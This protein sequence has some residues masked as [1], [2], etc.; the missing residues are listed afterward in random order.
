MLHLCHCTRCS[1]QGICAEQCA[2]NLSITREEQDE[3]AVQSYKRSLSAA[4]RG[5]FKQQ[6]VPVTVEQ[7]K[8]TACV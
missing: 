6:I 8:G 2:K 7:K 5:V 1:W 4:E 3:Y